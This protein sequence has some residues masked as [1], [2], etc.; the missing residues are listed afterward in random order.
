MVNANFD[1]NYLKA[2]TFNVQCQIFSLKVILSF[3]RGSNEQAHDF[4]L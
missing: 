1:D 2:K 3:N 4:Y